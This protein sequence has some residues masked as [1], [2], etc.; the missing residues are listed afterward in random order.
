MIKM[1]MGHGHKTSS[2]HLNLTVVFCTG[3]LCICMSGAL[4]RVRNTAM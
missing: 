1:V 4:P 3:A 2:P